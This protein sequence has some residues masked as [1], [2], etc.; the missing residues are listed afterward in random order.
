MFP[1]QQILQ[2]SKLFVLIRTKIGQGKP[3]QQSSENEWQN[4]FK[5]SK[6]AKINLILRTSID[7]DGLK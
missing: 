5:T 4:G 7:K 6:I 2:K 1:K 3:E